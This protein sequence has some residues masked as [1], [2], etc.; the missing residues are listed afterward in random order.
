MY[1]SNSK[2]ISYTA[3]FFMLIGFAVA[4]L[5]VA[6]MLSIPVWT[7]MTGTG[8]DKMTAEMN[9]P[10]Y[11]HAYQVIQVITAVVGFFLP[12]ILVAFLLNRKPMKLIGFSGTPSRL[13]FFVALLI[14]F[15]GLFASA[16]FSYFNSH[17]PVPA[18]WKIHFDKLE[19]E[20]NSGV[21]SIISLNS[22]SQ[23][24]FALFMLA[25]LPAICEETLF[26]GGLQN[27][28]TRSTKKPWLS[29]IIVS[30]IF[31]LAHFSYYGFLS[32]LFL[33]IMLG[34]LYQ[35]SGKIWINIFGHFLNNGIAITVL[36]VSILNGQSLQDAM[37]DNSDNFWGILALPVVII[38]F[39]WFYKV[40]I[41]GRETVKPPLPPDNSANLFS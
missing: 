35:Y 29:I 11:A 23:F 26:R 21:E 18:D 3:G 9:N 5:L 27:F 14:V 10:A 2:G 22:F 25:V 39:V 40:S 8:M 4:A 15:F 31:S 32:R 28:L 12:A 33:G 17:L 7:A 30:I 24:L 38:L 37:K 36:Y 20:Y 13:Q 6:G 16:G 1:D 19:D 34:L 41:K